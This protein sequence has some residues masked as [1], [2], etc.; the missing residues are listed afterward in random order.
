MKAL[1][2]VLLGASVLLS[3]L[4]VLLLGDPRRHVDAAVAWF[5]AST[6][7]AALAIDAALFAAVLGAVV[8]PWVFAV[9]LLAQDVVFGWRLWFVVRERLRRRRR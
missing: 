7:W 2:G 9:A 1:F 5:L 3:L 8:P 4:F 6:G